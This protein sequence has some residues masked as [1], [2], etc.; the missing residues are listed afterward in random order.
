MVIACG[1]ES[2]VEVLPHDKLLFKYQL[3]IE[4]RRD[5]LQLGGTERDGHWPLIDEQV[6]QI[7]EDW[8]CDFLA[9]REQQVKLNREKWEEEQPSGE[10]ASPPHPPLT[11]E[12]LC[13]EKKKALNSMFEGML[14][15]HL[16]ILN[17]NDQNMNGDDILCDGV[18]LVRFLLQHGLKYT[19][20]CKSMTLLKNHVWCSLILVQML[21]LNCQHFHLIKRT[22]KT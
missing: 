5:A 15:T 1:K 18:T 19:E 7:I 13:L 17:P 20:D 22:L 8:K 9:L 2:L 11:M 16:A 4:K 12:R 14:Q 6:D 10:N 21:F 3:V